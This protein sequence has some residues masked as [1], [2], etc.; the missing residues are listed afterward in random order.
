MGAEGPQVESSGFLDGGRPAPAEAIAAA[1]ARGVDLTGHISRQLTAEALTEADVVFVMDPAQRGALGAYGARAVVLLLG[2][3]DPLD[4]ETRRIPDPFDQ[5]RETFDACYDRIDRCVRIVAGAVLEPMPR[6]ASA[7]GM[8]TAGAPRSARRSALVIS[9]HFPPDGAVGG[10]RWLGLSR[11]LASLGWRV[12]V[13]TAAS[14]LAPR[15]LHHVD[16]TTC[17]RLPTLNDWYRRLVRANQ[18][19]RLASRHQASGKRNSRVDR[20]R[21]E[22]SALLELPDQSRGWIWRA[23]LRTRS[24]IR[25]VQ[26]HVV[27]SS[28][29]PH[30]AHVVAALAT[31]GT[32]VRWLIDLR[33]PWWS[34]GGDL[35]RWSDVLGSG[36]ARRLI[37]WLERQT[38][39]AADGII[40]NT[41]ELAQA[42]RECYPS[43]AVVW[44]RNGV[45]HECLPADM[46]ERDPGFVVSYVGTLYGNRELTQVLRGLRTLLD[47]NTADATTPVVLRVAG[48]VEGA[49]EMDLRDEIERLGLTANV[50]LLGLIPP[51]EAL[52]VSVRSD[53][54]VVLAQDQDLQIPA[55]LYELVAMRIPTLV[56]ASAPTATAREAR[57]LGLRVVDPRDHEAIVDTLECARSRD[58]A[59]VPPPNPQIDYSYL[60]RKLEPIL[61]D[62]DTFTAAA[63]TLRE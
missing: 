60:A 31:A 43:A 9:Y 63:A 50:E 18:R 8:A 34:P 6:L 12:N 40:A 37:P 38:F 33:D 3:F 24:L 58:A 26:P 46:G 49:H 42:L 13:L 7:P 29:P 35:G 2:D 36:S 59:L 52:R 45:D 44:L 19:A 20:L 25:Q 56:L 32:R 14:G 48:H 47:R 57:D 22:I 15:T 62:R 17:R 28:G 61:E 30:S 39:R 10:L 5:P 51:S 11:H 55:K 16:I 27:V 4:I 1:K 53:L 21:L 54:A 23:V 41:R